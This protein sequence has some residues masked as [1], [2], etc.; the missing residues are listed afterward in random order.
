[1][2]RILGKIQ[3]VFPIQVAGQDSIIEEYQ[4]GDVNHRLDVRFILDRK[5]ID[6]I[7]EAMNKSNCGLVCMGGLTWR[8]QLRQTENGT[9][10]GVVK[11]NTLN[12]KP[13]TMK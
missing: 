2:E 4:I 3:Q 11:L 12:P 1:M 13:M 8:I 7:V 5:S 6:S 9:N 10:Y